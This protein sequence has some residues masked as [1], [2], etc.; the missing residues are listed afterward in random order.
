MLDVRKW[1]YAAHVHKW[2]DKIQ[3][4]IFGTFTSMK[5]V[6]LGGGCDIGRSCLVLTI[7]PYTIMLDC[8]VHMSDQ[9]RFPDFDRL[10]LQSIV[11]VVVVTH[12]HLDHV[13]ALPLFTQGKTP[14]HGHVLM[15]PPTK[16]ISSIVLND[17]ATSTSPHASDKS[18]SNLYTQDD[19]KECMKKVTTMNLNQAFTVNDDLSITF[20]YA[21]MIR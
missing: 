13:G 5:V 11:D 17:F 18:P 6:C 14:Y 8:G 2:R 10:S 7:G 4:F 9:H 21:G 16:Y 20:Y 3:I 1:R 19:V 12:Y 15:S